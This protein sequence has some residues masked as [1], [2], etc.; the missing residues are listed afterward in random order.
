M[1]SAVGSEKSSAWPFYARPVIDSK[2]AVERTINTSQF[3]DLPEDIR[4]TLNRGAVHWEEKNYPNPY[5]NER[6]KP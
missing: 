5:G 3:G 6:R 4:E 1:L 2:G